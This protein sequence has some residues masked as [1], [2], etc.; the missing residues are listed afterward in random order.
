MKFFLDTAVLVAAVLEEHE[1]YARSFSVL[2]GSSPSAA[3]CAAHNLAEVYVTLTR[4]PGRDRLS[5][6]QALLSLEKIEE[7]LTVVTLDAVAY[8]A[9]IRRFAA[10]GIVGAALYDGLIAAC[11]LKAKV[12]VIYTWNVA[13]FMRLGDD[14]AR[15]VRTP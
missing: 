7:R 12:D 2:S 3:F 8:S 9:A 4:Y 1:H 14:V 6:E 13:D 15:R 10:L 5:A 11:A